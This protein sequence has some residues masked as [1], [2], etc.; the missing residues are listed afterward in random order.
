MMLNWTNGERSTVGGLSP[1][2]SD[3][4]WRFGK[5]KL[6][7]FGRGQPTHQ[8]PWGNPKLQATEDG[9]SLAFSVCGRHVL[10]L[11]QWKTR[12]R[13]N[14]TWGWKKFLLFLLRDCATLYLVALSC[15]AGKNAGDSS[16]LQKGARSDWGHD[17]FM[18]EHWKLYIWG[19][20]KIGYP[21]IW[22]LII[23]IVLIKMT[24]L[25]Y[26]PFLGKPKF[27]GVNLIWCYFWVYCLPLFGMMLVVAHNTWFWNCSLY[28]QWLDRHKRIKWGFL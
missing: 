1:K 11:Q 6:L 18:V 23:I 24:I 21:Q 7:G 10:G 8:H 28:T 4:L 13:R 27:T 15:K 22:W 20:L 3:I 17:A 9:F 26:S 5:R 16:C 14:Q 12:R 25:W 19:C 2:C